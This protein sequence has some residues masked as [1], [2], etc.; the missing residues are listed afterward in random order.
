[1][2]FIS[3]RFFIGGCASFGAMS[4]RAMFAAPSFSLSKVN[5]RMG[6]ISD[7]HVR[8]PKHSYTTEAVVRAFEYFRDNG[9]DAVMVAGDIAD[10]GRVHQLKYFADA[11]YRVFPGD[12]APDGRRVEKLFIYGNHDF[13]GAGKGADRTK[14]QIADTIG[15][16]AESR[17]RVW[18][19]CFNEKYEPVW[20]KNVKGYDIVGCHWGNGA[21]LKDFFSK[22]A[23]RL[24]SGR[25]FFYTQHAHPKDTC[26]GSWAWGHDAG[27]STKALSAFP[28]AVAFTGHSHYP[29]TDE[30][31]VW[32]GAFTSINT[33]SMRYSSQDYSLRDNLSG[34]SYGYSAWKR[35]APTPN[36]RTG[37]GKHG[38]FVEVGD[39]G[40][41]IRRR[42]FTWGEPIGDD[43]VF[44]AGNDRPFEY[45]RR[46]RSRKAPVFP[47]ESR[48]DVKAVKAGKNGE[49][50]VDVVIPSAEAV[51]GCRVFEYEVSS[52]IVQD[53]VE[54]TVDT[55]RVA[56]A[57]FHL[58]AKKT[59]RATLCRIPASA[60]PPK[61]SLRFDVRA[62]E[63]F[64][65][66]SEPLS[67]DRV[68]LA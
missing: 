40:M 20:I 36:L 26:F 27:E 51:D 59:G 64:G 32:Q 63:C 12:R 43:W 19:E 46:K 31:S 17:A 50:F 8:D 41:V 56:A 11:W 29:L 58:P 57:D 5:F 1:M 60:L 6:V 61:A 7:V 33:S 62:L 15:E 68:H 14:E 22:N 21:R 37:E 38:M 30:R 45:A 28:D 2:S 9:A 47:P 18:E 42:D 48:L 55:R 10:N 16:T 54:M 3:R 53:D 34:N 24:K 23:A 44:P 49:K 66:K 4:P 39:E 35:P 52:V 25:P 65:A 67:S 13:Y